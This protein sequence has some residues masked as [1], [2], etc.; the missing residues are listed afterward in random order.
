M[1][2]W[3]SVSLSRGS[4][5]LGVNYNLL[6]SITTFLRI[7]L[8]LES[9]QNHAVHTR[10]GILMLKFCTAPLRVTFDL[11]N[12]NYLFANSLPTS[13]CSTASLI[14][15]HCLIS[16]E[17]TAHCSVNSRIPIKIFCWRNMEHLCRNTCYA[18]LKPVC[19][20]KPACGVYCSM[21]LLQCICAHRTA[22][23]SAVTCKQVLR[24]ITCAARQS[25]RG[26]RKEV[27]WY[28]TKRKQ[29]GKRQLRE[30]LRNERCYRYRRMSWVH[31]HDR[32]TH[33]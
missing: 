3:G 15:R 32:H 10:V 25:K 21:P 2:S 27:K 19:R 7:A 5:L 28:S 22:V 26:N 6:W 17:L 29:S 33:P 23:Q 1:T 16:S 9:T 20:V 13:R 31:I 11:T 24:Q 4:I 8:C 14:W 30:Q 12:L 18:Y